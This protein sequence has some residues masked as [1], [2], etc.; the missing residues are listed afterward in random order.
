[1]AIKVKVCGM[2]RREDIEKALELGVDYIGINLHQDSPRSVK[3]AGV[4]DLIAVIPPGKRVFVDVDTPTDQLES[5]RSYGF[6]YYQLHFD[7]NLA[8]ATV[9][10]WSGIVGR[11]NLW[12]APRIPPDEKYFP[13]ILMEF[14]NT[15][16]I[17]AYAK[18]RHGGTGL[19]GTNWQRF[20]DCSTMYQHKNWI[21]AGGLGPETIAEALAATYPD[22]VDINSAVESAPGIKDPG[23]IRETI[24]IIRNHEASA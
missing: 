3:P 23:K 14:S 11:E 18:D 8:M 10:A 5:Y 4:A 12:L 20:L 21:L 9:A 16:L 19:S 7:L 1:M 2:T 24:E 22:W 13:Q 15:L 6:D 17:D